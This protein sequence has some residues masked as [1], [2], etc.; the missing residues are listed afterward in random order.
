VTDREQIEHTLAALEAQRAV[1]G[2]DVVD[3]AL[4]SL[5]EKLAAL[6]PTLESA[7][8]EQRKQ[9]TVLFADLVDFTALAA[10]LDPE[11]V[12]EIVNAYFDLWSRIITQHGGMVEKFIGDAVM[13]VFGLPAAK[14][15]DPENAIRSALAMRWGLEELNLN[16][17]RKRGLQLAMRVG[18][19]TGPVLASYLGGH[20]EQDF[21]VVGDTVNLASRLEQ[22]APTHGILISHDTYRHVRGIFSVR[23]QEPLQVKGKAELLQS[24]LVRAAKPR[25]FRVTTRG[26]EGLETRMIGRRAELKT[27]QDAFYTALDDEQLQVFTIVGEAG[28]GKSR[29]LY[30]F[31]NWVEVQPDWSVYFR[32]RATQ[33]MMSAPYAL[34]RSLLMYRFEILDSDPLPV[35]RGKLTQ[36]IAEFIKSD[37]ALEKAHYIGQLIGIDFSDSPFIH[38]PLA[39]AKLIRDRAFPFLVE[40]FTKAARPSAL[41]AVALIYLEDIHW[42]DAG[43]LDAFAYLAEHSHDQPIMIVSLARPSLYERRPEWLGGHLDLQPLLAGERQALVEEILHRVAD[44][45]IQ[46]RDLIA[47]RAEGSPFYTEE[48]IKMLIDDGVILV[49]NDPW[50]I[51]PGRLSALRVPPTLVGVIQARLDSLTPAERETLQRAA[52]VGRVFWDSAVAALAESAGSQPDDFEPLKRKELIYQRE[53]AAFVGTQE[54][55]FKHSILR[56]VTYESVLRRARRTYHAQVAQ[57]MIANSGGRA[58]EYAG[59]IAEHYEQAGESRLAAEWYGRAGK[60]AAE[61]Y[62]PLVAIDFYQRALNL[63]STDD[64]ANQLEWQLGLG[65]ELHN[66]ARYVEASQAFATMRAAAEALND[67]EAQARAWNRLA[68]VQ[69]AQGDYQGVLV[70]AQKAEALAQAAGDSVAAQTELADALANIAW[71]Y[72][73]MGEEATKVIPFAERALTIS[74]ALGVKRL[75][76]SALN[77]LGVTFYMQGDLSTSAEK[78]E[79]ALTLAR[80][81]GNRRDV[82][83][84]LNN[85]GVLAEARGELESALS[86]YSEAIVI[87][88]E[89]EDR[90]RLL[91]ALENLGSVQIRLGN[92]VE[93]EAQVRQVLSMTDPSAT[94]SRSS[95]YNTL[96]L[97]C[98]HQGRMMEALEQAQKALGLAQ[99]QNDSEW[100]GNAWMTLGLIAVELGQIVIGDRAY[101]PR[102][103]FAESLRVF[104]EQNQYIGRPEVLREWARYEFSLGDSVRG[105]ELWREAR[106]FFGRVGAAAEVERM[107]KER[108]V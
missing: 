52:V 8:G 69:E 65:H 64:L 14:E 59:L 9:V 12:R 67:K 57:W 16:L 49:E 61:T 80:E 63:I 37:A 74:R 79:Q 36:G 62:A 90:D 77:L 7:G 39:D 70:S 75:A 5:R 105:L 56:D 43:S 83:L 73:R 47:D 94:G 44:L 88:R 48:L 104:G 92:Y 81:I 25:A 33:E 40:L 91:L 17:E 97:A 41:R 18:I 45:P 93:A 1:L 51:A 3:T 38:D 99:L 31:D 21:T 89:T 76:A 29:L 13:A 106:E 85:L 42:A 20:R 46:L 54:F 10:A 95:T 102:A 60:Q 107:D 34:L 108:K 72:C 68:S 58:N 96:A 30:E 4:A 82:V 28:L 2:D 11:D 98:L 71:A 19:H 27:L 24:Y 101:D 50:Q 23:A 26:V 100:I 55:T 78:F 66:Q 84:L 32:G 86:F 6:Q 15:G 35:A 53:P 87:A 22:A 103:C